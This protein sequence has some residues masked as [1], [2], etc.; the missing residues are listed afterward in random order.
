MQAL[1]GQQRVHGRAVGVR[2]RVDVHLPN[3]AQVERECGGEQA[4]AGAQGERDAV[5]VIARERTIGADQRSRCGHP[6]HGRQH[7]G[8][9]AGEV[10][11]RWRPCT[12]RDRPEEVVAED[13]ARE[14]RALHEQQHDHGPPRV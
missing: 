13:Q 1:P 4:Q 9:A 5:A 11:R 8:R 14:D 6:A 3:R 12:G 7:G 2:C 10:E